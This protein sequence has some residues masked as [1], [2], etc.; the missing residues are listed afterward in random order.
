MTHNSTLLLGVRVDLGIENGTNRNLVPIFLFDF[1]TPQ[2]VV[3][4]LAAI[5]KGD[6][7]RP[8]SLG[9][10]GDVGSGMDGP[11]R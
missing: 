11:I 8:P 10:K 9:V 2:S 3:A 1:Y 4:D 5:S 7:L 6:F